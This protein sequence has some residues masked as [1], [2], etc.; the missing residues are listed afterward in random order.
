MTLTTSVTFLGLGEMGRT[1]AAAVAKTSTSVTVWNRTPGRTGELA[2]AT[3][4]NTVEE[5]VAAS[6]V[7]V[8]CLFDHASVHQTLDPVVSQLRGRAVVNLTTTNQDEARE[9]G[10]WAAAAGI[11]YLDGGIMAVPAMIGGPGSEILYSGS[12]EAFERYREIFDTWGT[13]SYFGPD[14]GLASLYDLAL[15]A[16]MYVMF[17]G[18][19]QGA[20]MVSTAGVSAREFAERSAAW[21]SAMTAGFAEYAA[22]VDGGDYAA[23][24]QQSLEFSDLA[25]MIEATAALDIG[26]QPIA[27]VQSLIQQQ[28]D[29]GYR[30]DGLPR[31]YES[32]R[33]PG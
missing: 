26:A 23:P 20:A 22:V 11:E 31:I 25:K 17:A 14:A 5:A 21:L 6:P 33:N 13:S 1:L 7:I 27:M 12:R 4:A 24:G 10:Q 18:F 28:I 8:V 9:L 3:V 29:A 32:I 2:G 19:F 16:G 15:L 30:A